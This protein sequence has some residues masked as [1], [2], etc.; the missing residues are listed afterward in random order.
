MCDRA[1]KKNPEDS[2]RTAG[3]L[4]VKM[5]SG[6]G[7]IYL[8]EKWKLKGSKSTRNHNSSSSMASSSSN[9]HHH[10]NLMR[11]SSTSSANHLMRNSS[12]SST[13]HLIRNASTS[14]SSTNN[15]MRNSSKRNGGNHNKSGFS[16]KCSSLVKEQRAKFYIVRRCVTMLMCWRDY[17]DS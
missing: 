12:T 17:N 14:S 10:H 5:S 8:D 7:Q 4:L 2:R 16:R 15:L 13:S 3:F 9:H 1:E 6:N 11:S